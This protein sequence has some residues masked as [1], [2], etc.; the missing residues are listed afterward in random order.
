MMGAFAFKGGEKQP[1][2]LEEQIGG[3]LLAYNS[4]S[5]EIQFATL[6]AS[7]A[8]LL[9]ENCSRLLKGSMGNVQI[10]PNDVEFDWVNKGSGASFGGQLR[11][12]VE[13]ESGEKFIMRVFLSK[14]S[15]RPINVHASRI[16]LGDFEALA[17]A[18]KEIG[19]DGKVPDALFGNLLSVLDDYARKCGPIE[20]QQLNYFVT[21]GLNHPELYS[22]ELSISDSPNALKR[23]MVFKLVP[24]EESNSSVKGTDQEMLK[25]ELSVLAGGTRLMYS[26]EQ[27]LGPGAEE[28]E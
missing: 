14:D 24:T 21:L 20:K 5:T 23:E 7:A 26:F 13:N 3:V 8:K 28:G 9:S 10:R 12:L 4:S 27:D 2:T 6:R 11:A 1:K 25:V 17:N 15:N 22:L 19:S 18:A 16:G